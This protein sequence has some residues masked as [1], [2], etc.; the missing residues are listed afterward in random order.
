MEIAIATQSSS[1]DATDMIPARLSQQAF[2]A[3]VVDATGIV[4]IATFS[5]PSR[6]W[7]EE[8]TDDQVE[9][10]TQDELAAL[11]ILDVDHNHLLGEAWGHDVDDQLVD[12]P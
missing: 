1:A 2:T 3:G 10:P 11:M 7:L 4:K 6:V 8:I 9:S 5:L 12:N